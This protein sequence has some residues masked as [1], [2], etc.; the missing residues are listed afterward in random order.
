METARERNMVHVQQNEVGLMDLFKILYKNRVMIAVI[1]VIVALASL[2]GAIY[3][4][5]NKRNLIAINFKKVNGIDPFY[6]NRANLN[7]NE[8][9]IENL[10]KQDDIVEKMYKNSYLNDKFLETGVA[11]NSDERRNFLEKAVRVKAIKE[12]KILKYYQLSMENQGAFQNEKKVME[13]YLNILNEKLAGAYTVRIDE[14]HGVVKEKKEGYERALTEIEAEINEVISKEPKEL[15]ENEKAWDIIQAKHPRLFE[16]QK[17]I[18]ELYTKYGDE[19]VGIEGIKEDFDLNK[20]VNK[21][22]SFYEIKQRSKAKLILVI[23]IIFG[24]VFGVMGAFI[25]E[26]WEHLKKEAN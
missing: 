14:R 17:K 15:F 20:Q 19:L 2:G 11:D 21:I 25:R 8:I 3:V 13:T 1:T 22:S 18:K 9:E 7:V 24:L 10:F 16:R 23:G 26:F 4:R 6:I 12:G 5:S